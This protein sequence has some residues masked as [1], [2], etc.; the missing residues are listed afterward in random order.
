MT[1]DIS[2]L[3]AGGLEIILPFVTSVFNVPTTY[4]QIRVANDFFKVLLLYKCSL[5]I[6]GSVYLLIVNLRIN[7]FIKRAQYLYVNGSLQSVSGNDGRIAC[8]SSHSNY[9]KR[10]VRKDNSITF[11]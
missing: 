10:F 5:H 6:K 3:D 1:E 2:R 4:Q 9:C 11:H 7:K 8:Y